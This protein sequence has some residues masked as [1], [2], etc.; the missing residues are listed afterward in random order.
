MDWDVGADYPV[1]GFE[2]TSLHR[3]EETPEVRRLMQIKFKTLR[4]TVYFLP[5]SDPFLET[6]A[7]LSFNDDDNT[8]GECRLIAEVENDN[9]PVAA[10]RVTLSHSRRAGAQDFW[11]STHWFDALYWYREYV[12]T[13]AQPVLIQH[14]NLLLHDPQ[15]SEEAERMSVQEMALY[16][17]RNLPGD[18]RRVSPSAVLRELWQDRSREIADNDRLRVY[19]DNEWFK[20]VNWE[21]G[22]S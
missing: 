19:W 18:H 14:M 9:M 7:V 17:V 5:S 12:L 4:L 11:K 22:E 13:Q 2:A 20:T 16:F 15:L 3:I 8:L 10:W 1:A 6:D 21:W